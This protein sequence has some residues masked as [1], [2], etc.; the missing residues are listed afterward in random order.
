[1]N[2]VRWFA[3]ETLFYQIFG[4]NVTILSAHLAEE[5]EMIYFRYKMKFLHKN[6]IQNAKRKTKQNQTAS[7]IIITFTHE[8]KT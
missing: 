8:I 4:P 6:Y 1:M 3:T 5:S 7:N 2:I